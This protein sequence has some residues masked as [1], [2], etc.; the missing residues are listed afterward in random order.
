MSYI[1]SYRFAPGGSPWSPT[2][3]V[4]DILA[5]WDPNVGVTFHSGTD[6]ATWTDKVQSRVLNAEVG[7]PPTFSSTGLNS[8]PIL[9]FE[10]GSNA[11]MYGAY[12]YTGIPFMC[13]AVM[14]YKDGGSAFGR[15]ISHGNT[16]LTTDYQQDDTWQLSRDNLTTTIGA[17]RNNV[18]FG[19][20]APGYD[21]WFMLMLVFDGTN[22]TMY[23]DDAVA[24]TPT[25]NSAA[26]A[27]NRL[28]LFYSADSTLDNDFGQGRIA[29][30]ITM[31]RAP[32][33]SERNKF[34]GWA[35]HRYGLTSRLDVSHPYKSS[36]PTV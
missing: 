32:T 1:N 21:T 13:F 18:T 10:S 17:N 35:A 16:T 28:A 22:Q 24:G 12:V 29:D 25:A 8:L 14:R 15:Y 11:R 4:D 9:T 20:A 19:D 26:F 31:H 2:V 34:F 7:T 5:W 36:P 23:I 30:V 3:I 27:T 6:V 33:T